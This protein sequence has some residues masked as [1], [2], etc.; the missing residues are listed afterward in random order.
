MEI[1]I[2]FKLNPSFYLRNNQFE[3]PFKDLIMPLNNMGKHNYDGR[4]Q[5]H[6]RK[7][8]VI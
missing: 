1:K 2:H 5:A 4:G 6:G 8:T 3:K 7:W